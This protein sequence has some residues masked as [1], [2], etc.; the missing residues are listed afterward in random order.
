MGVDLGVGMKN[1]SAARHN[2]G[3]MRREAEKERERQLHM[4]VGGVA[5]NLCI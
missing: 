2:I 4:L 3:N 1:W 5:T